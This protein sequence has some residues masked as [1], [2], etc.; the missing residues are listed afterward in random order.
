MAS[1][2]AIKRRH[3]ERFRAQGLRP[4]QVWVPDV[5]APEFVIAAHEQSLEIAASE[6]EPDDQ[7]FVDATSSGWDG[8]DES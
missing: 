6:Q 7:A 3:R 8:A 2:R 5:R 1:A 4:M